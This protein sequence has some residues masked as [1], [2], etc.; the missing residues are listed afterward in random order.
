MDDGIGKKRL[1]SILKREAK[2]SETMSCFY[3]N[4]LKEM[5]EI[6]RPVR[7]PIEV[8][9]VEDMKK[10]ITF[11]GKLSPSSRVRF[12]RRA[13]NEEKIKLAEDAIAEPDLDIKGRAT[14][15]FFFSR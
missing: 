5:E 8:P 11:S 9:S 4:Y 14:I 12:S 10:E 3:E 1:L 2:K 7:K 13:E 15:C 6:E